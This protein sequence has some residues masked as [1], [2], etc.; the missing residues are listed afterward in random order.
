MREEA[1][2]ELLRKAGASWDVVE[3]MIKE[4]KLIELEYNGKKFYMRKLGS[5]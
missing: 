4:G 5:R 3:K 2:R 1:V